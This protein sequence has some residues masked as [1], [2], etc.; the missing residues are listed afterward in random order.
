MAGH[1]VRNTSGAAY[2]ADPAA[3]PGT[4]QKGEKR[5]ILQAVTPAPRNNYMTRRK[6]HIYALLIGTLA[7][8]LILASCTSNTE[9]FYKVGEDSIPTLYTVAGQKK[10]VGTRTGFENGA[11]YKYVQYGPGVTD[12]EMQQYID[13]LEGIGYVQIGDTEINGDEQKV[14]M[15]ANSVSSG[16]MIL[17]NI[18]LDPADVT[19]IDYTVKDGFIERG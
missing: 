3:R 13:A 7:L 17:V 9:E 18:T 12:Q 16:K 1:P 2:Q 5:R 4:K 8:A 11:S 6:C 10:I 19:Q 15:G 14:L